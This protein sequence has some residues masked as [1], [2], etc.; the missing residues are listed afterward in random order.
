M[1]AIV[2]VFMFIC[3]AILFWKVTE[4]TNEVEE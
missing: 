2:D 1:S 3:Y 4:I